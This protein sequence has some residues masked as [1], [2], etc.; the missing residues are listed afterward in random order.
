MS[1]PTIVEPKP[2]STNEMEEHAECIRDRLGHRLPV[3]PGIILITG[4]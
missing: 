2:L 3:E 1:A 4:G